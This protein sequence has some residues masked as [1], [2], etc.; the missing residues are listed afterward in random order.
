MAAV[1]PVLK[2]PRV[3]RFAEVVYWLYWD[4]FDIS[5]WFSFHHLSFW[6]PCWQLSAW[7]FVCFGHR[8]LGLCVGYDVGASGAMSC[9]AQKDIASEKLPPGLFWKEPSRTLAWGE[10]VGVRVMTS[11]VTGDETA[12]KPVSRD[13]KRASPKLSR[14]ILSPLQLKADWLLNCFDGNLPSL[15]RC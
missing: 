2:K 12:W 3:R 11:G 8:S 6:N 14:F 1:T 13:R 4:L 15:L 9:S 5:T 7:V 10:A